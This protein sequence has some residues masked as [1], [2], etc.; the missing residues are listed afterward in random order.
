MTEGKSEEEEVGSQEEHPEAQGHGAPAETPQAPEEAL[1]SVPAEGAVGASEGH[2][3]PEAAPLLAQ[4]AG[5]P[6]GPPESPC[7]C[8]SATPSV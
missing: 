5:D 7:A 2:G 8:G 6:A 4:E 1:C 3:E